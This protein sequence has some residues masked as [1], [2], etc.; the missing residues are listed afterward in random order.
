MK[1]WICTYLF[2]F[3]CAIGFSQYQPILY[4][5]DEIPQALQ[6]NPGLKQDRSWFVGFPAL[7]QL[8]LSIGSSGPNVYDLLGDNAID[9][10]DKIRNIV[11]QTSHRDEAHIY[12]KLE[13]LSVGFKRKNTFYSFG[14]YQ[15]VDGIG[16]FPKDLAIL[17]LEGNANHIGKRF[18]LGHLKGNLDVLT[19]LH[20]GMQKSINDKWTIGGRLK[21]YNSILNI[22]STKSKGYFTTI[23]GERNIYNHSYN[24]VLEI[25]SSNFFHIKDELFGEEGD[26]NSLTGLAFFGGSLGLGVDLGLTYDPNEQWRFTA[27]MLDLG[28]IRQN[29]NVETYRLAGNYSTE[30]LEVVLPVDQTEELWQNLVD[31]I[32]KEVPLD[33]IKSA[34]TNTRPLK[35]YTSFNYNFGKHIQDQDCDCELGG[36]TKRKIIY[37]NSF[38]SQLFLAKRPLGP[39]AALSLY[40]VRRFGNWLRFKTTYTIDKYSL[41]NIGAGIGLQAANVQLY[42]MGDNLLA[43]QDLTKAQR[44]SFQ[45]GIN[46]L[47]SN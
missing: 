12:Q 37:K 5:F 44:A 32:E 46:I 24:G 41:T 31:E 29:K 10:N 25:Q 34:Y 14:F 17:G 9:F 40:Y 8:Q 16:Y 11:Y 21:I 33:T 45:I 43:L 18:D 23:Q 4:N 19:V 38:G 6:L 47:S 7:S 39:K 35:I 13:L 22:R 1:N 3:S 36:S 2:F 30:G 42:I 28:F 27:S 26:P 15:E 20:A